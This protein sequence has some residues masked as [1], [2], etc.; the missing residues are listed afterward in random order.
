MC[1]IVGLFAKSSSIE[2][3]FGVHPAG[4]SGRWATAGRTVPASPSTATG[5][6]RIKQTHTLRRG[7]ASRST[8][9]SAG[10]EQFA[11]QLADLDLEIVCPVGMAA[12]TAPADPP[13]NVTHLGH[14]VGDLVNEERAA[15]AWLRSLPADNQSNRGQ[16]AQR[17]STPCSKRSRYSPKVVSWKEAHQP[18]SLAWK[19]ETGSSSSQTSVAR[20]WR[21]CSSRRAR[22]V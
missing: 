6:R 22:P 2:D 16:R 7:S 14:A 15:A 1:G 20:R 21:T 3:R 4:C 11:T 12:G 8:R 9:K 18:I 5:L 17:G 19:A 10:P 13:E